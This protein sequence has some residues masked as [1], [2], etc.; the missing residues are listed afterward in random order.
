MKSKIG[1]LAIVLISG[2][3]LS[4]CTNK[5]TSD[6]TA[7]IDQQIQNE[8]RPSGAPDDRAPGQQIDLV[9]A[10]EKLGVTEESLR[11][12]L[13]MNNMAQVTPGVETTP[14]ANPSG[15]P[16]K[17]DLAAAAKTLGV[18]EDALREALGMNNMPSGEPQRDGNGPQGSGKTTQ[19]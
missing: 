2:L 7:D 19:E 10:A 15:E 16:K 13:G 14:G 5:S 3:A 11:S 18:T 9:T 6:T 4:A 17:M 1:L 12:A 8:V